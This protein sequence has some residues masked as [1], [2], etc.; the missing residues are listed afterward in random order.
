MFELNPSTPEEAKQIGYRHLDFMILI[1]Y[2]VETNGDIWS[3]HTQ[4][5][6]GRLGAEWY[7]KIPGITNGYK[8]ISTSVYGKAKSVN[9]HTIVATSFHGP[10]P[11]GMECLHE[12]GNKANCHVANLHWGTPA[13]NEADK[14]RHGR[15]NQGER[16]G[17][18]KLNEITIYKIYLDYMLGTTQRVIAEHYCINQATV[19]KIVNRILWNHLLHFSTVV[20]IESKI[21][22]LEQI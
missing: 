17:L 5:C 4:G 12:D 16:H 2:L 9:V 8:Q 3:C 11:P 13:D 1:G 14:A 20:E 21:K 22:Q 10:C 6:K 18:A 15:S 19:S 7:R